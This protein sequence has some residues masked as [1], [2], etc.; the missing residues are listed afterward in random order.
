[1]DVYFRQSKLSKICNSDKL[2]RKA[3]GRRM[4]DKLGQRL[5]ELRAANCLG[6]ISR[7]RPC[8]CHKLTGKQTGQFS[9]D[10]ENPYRLLFVPAYEDDED[11][12]SE[13]GG[14][15]LSKIKEI[16]ILK[17]DDTHDPKFKRR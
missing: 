11:I 7:L 2:M 17:I 10:L 15:D 3:Y 5:W 13:D 1:M 12:F 16:E 14:F 6:D 9:V 4:A 8:R